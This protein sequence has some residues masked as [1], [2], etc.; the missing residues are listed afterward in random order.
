VSGSNLEADYR[1]FLERY[2]RSSHAATAKERI[3][4]M[5]PY[6]LSFQPSIKSGKQLELRM[7]NGEAPYQIR[8]TY[9][10][11]NQSLSRSLASRETLKV[12]LSEFNATQGKQLIEIEVVDVNFKRS[13]QKLPLI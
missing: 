1:R 12:S 8:I 10:A 6:Q 9:L 3:A 11:N 5:H 7:R 13:V 4:A 2:P